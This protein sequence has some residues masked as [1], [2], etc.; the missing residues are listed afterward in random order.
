MVKR[1]LIVLAIAAGL[2]WWYERAQTP[3]AEAP[4]PARATAVSS[5]QGAAPPAAK[6]PAGGWAPKAWSV[7]GGK[8]TPTHA[9][10]DRFDSY[11]P[12][13]QGVTMV[14]A[15]ATIEQDAQ[16]D[17]G[18]VNA[19]QVLGIWD[20]YARVQSYD[21]QRPFNPTEPKGWQA[22]LNEQHQVRRQLLGAEWAEAFFG[23]DEAAFQRRIASL[24]AARPAVN[25][26]Q[27]LDG[28]LASAPSSAGAGASSAVSAAASASRGAGHELDAVHAEREPQSP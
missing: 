13:G 4:Q 9:L 10:R 2:I 7:L 19:R 25:K 18:E 12:L 3:Q 23:E 24:V 28:V 16:A 14:E 1:T 22:T 21:W 27:S 15:R 11:L 17:L 5:E 8:L 20:R 26:P 6:R